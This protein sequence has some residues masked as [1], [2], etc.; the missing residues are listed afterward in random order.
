MEKGHDAGRLAE[1]GE[2]LLRPENKVR[3]VYPTRF[4]PDHWES[5]AFP[6]GEEGSKF[7]RLQIM[8]NGAQFS[9]NRWYRYALWRIWN[10]DK[11]L[12]MFI[13]LNPSTANERF[14]DPTIR[15]V[16]RFAY[17]WGAGGLY[18]MN[19]FAFVTPYPY[20]LAEAHDPVGD[21]DQWLERISGKCDKIIFAWGA[22]GDPKGR[23]VI[24]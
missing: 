7:K 19:L 11:P 21:N 17:D 15:R 6:E 16:I 23:N 18:M 2:V 8:S 24:R 13:G 5:E 1:A 4:R 10:E 3:G 20:E 9:E 22:F 14:N 12:I